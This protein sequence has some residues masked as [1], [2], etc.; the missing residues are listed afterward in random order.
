M[1]LPAAEELGSGQTQPTIK[2]FFIAF[3][4][5]FY[6]IKRKAT[7]N[8][9]QVAFYNTL[10]ITNDESLVFI[11][12]QQ[13]DELILPFEFLIIQFQIVILN[14]QEYVVDYHLDHMLSQK[15]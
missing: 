2:S 11:F 3:T 8:N 6:L 4:P 7:C 13:V 12:V 1:R 9:L 5:K 10:Q 14:Y 15:E